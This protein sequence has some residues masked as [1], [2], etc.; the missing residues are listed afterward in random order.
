MLFSFKKSL[1][2][3]LFWASTLELIIL[4]YL[5]IGDNKKNT[6]LTQIK[7]YFNIIIMQ[8]GSIFTS[9]FA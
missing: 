8:N 5:N 3:Y 1:Y 7:N 9:G 2:K 4:I 6:G